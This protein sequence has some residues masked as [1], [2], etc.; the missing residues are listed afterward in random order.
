MI[1]S[2]IIP[3]YDE[4]ATI[5]TV[6]AEVAAAP[7]PGYTKE[8]IVVD[9]GSS[10]ATAQEARRALDALISDT[11][12]VLVQPVNA[13]KGTAVRLGFAESTGDLVIVQDADL[14]YDPA[15]FEHLLDPIRR[16]RADLV[17]GSRFI[18]G[19]PRRVVYLTN[20]IGNRLMSGLFSVVSGLPLT[21][22]HCCYMLLPGDLARAS[23]PQLTSSRWGFNPEICSLIADWQRDLRIVEVGISYYGRSKQDGKKIR[24]RHG[25]VAVA[26]ILKFN[27]RRARPYPLPR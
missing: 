12:R 23:V 4:A 15:E 8:I 1:L 26:E 9:D 3:A 27:L 10:D 13:G 16:G 6:I 19:R 14:E 18:G 7:T 25:L 11:G 20:A 5:G 2:V 17:M 22:V 24:M 21:D